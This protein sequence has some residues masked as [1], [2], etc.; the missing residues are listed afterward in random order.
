MGAADDFKKCMENPQKA[1]HAQLSHQVNH[2]IEQN[3][4][5]IASIAKCVLFCGRQGIALRG[6]REDATADTS[7]NRGNF[8]ALFRLSC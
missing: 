1:V 8:L 7:S 2:Q 5:I 4:K 6:H 3:R